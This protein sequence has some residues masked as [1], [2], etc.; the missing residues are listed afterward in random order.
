M[1]AS[2]DDTI[3]HTTVG[4]ALW[5]ISAPMSLGILG[6][7]LI[8]LADAFF[9]ARVGEAELAAIGFVYPVIV[10]FSAFSIG[11]SAGANTVLSQ[12]IGRD[13][14]RLH[15]AK[16][17]FHA[18][19]F[20]AGLGLGVAAV[21]ILSGSWLFG[22]LGARDAVLDA[23]LVYLPW[24]AASF[25]IL[26][27]TMILNA[28][29][30]AAGDGTTPSAMMV[31]TAILNIAL[32]PLFVFGW[33]PVEAFG[34]A[35]AGMATFIARAIAG[36]LVLTL[37]IWRGRLTVRRCDGPGLRASVVEI[38]SVGLPAAASRAVNPAGMA[39]VTAAVATVG[40]QAVAGF[41]AAARVQSVTLVPFFALSAGLAPVVGQAWGADLPD[42]A[43]EAVRLGTW[44]A[45]AYGL[46]AGLALWIFATPLAQAMTDSGTAADFTARYLAV[47]GWSLAGYGLVI[48]ANAALTARS[49]ATWALGLSLTRIGVFYVP[50]AWIG[51]GAFGYA[52]IL[53]AAVIANAMGA[54]LA[55][56]ATQVNELSRAR[57][58]FLTAPASA[59][60]RLTRPRHG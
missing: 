45:V 29:F 52:G 8:G 14:P 2:R 10:A 7:L 55:L 36:A 42:R 19:L 30:R 20:G 32:T 4:R 6:V 44:V 22:A 56:S 25:P 21:L 57:W 18:A 35:G 12:A 31:L 39:L 37:T 46:I 26:V 16:M 33:G 3:T 59:M 47:V 5:R 48:A 58:R 43:R 15:V 34:M 27:V 38:T 49:R 9:L 13:A 54:W 28:A 24:W 1:S 40:D 23:I 51:V 41:G 11:M 17:T 50:L 53:A 60:Q